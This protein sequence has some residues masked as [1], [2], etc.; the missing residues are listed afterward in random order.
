MC[1]LLVPGP[2]FIAPL[3]SPGTQWQLQRVGVGWEGAKSQ[4]RMDPFPFQ[5]DF[6]IAIWALHMIEGKKTGETLTNACLL[7]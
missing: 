3:Q 4:W 6:R 1:Q 7:S 2:S 5:A